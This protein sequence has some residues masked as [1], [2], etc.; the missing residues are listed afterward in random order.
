MHFIQ[1]GMIKQDI[2]KLFTKHYEKIKIN[3]GK[4]S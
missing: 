4:I 2:I 3:G 1:L